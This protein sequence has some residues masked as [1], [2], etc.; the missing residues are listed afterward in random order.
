MRVKEGRLKIM[1]KKAKE[2]QKDEIVYIPA[3]KD[4]ETLPGPGVPVY[5]VRVFDHCLIDNARD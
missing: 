1:D 4:G 2:N 5:W 3:Q